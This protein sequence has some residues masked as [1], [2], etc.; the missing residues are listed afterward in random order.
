MKQN[1]NSYPFLVQIV[2]IPIIWIIAVFKILITIP[3]LIIGKCNSIINNF[4]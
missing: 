2:C 3:I 1:L 4:K